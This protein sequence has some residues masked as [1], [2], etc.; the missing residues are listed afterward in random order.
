MTTLLDC[1]IAKETPDIIKIR[2]NNY[3]H[4]KVH[5][6]CL[7]YPEAVSIFLELLIFYQNPIKFAHNKLN[8]KP[9]TV[10]HG[11]LNHVIKDQLKGNQRRETRYNNKDGAAEWNHLCRCRVVSSIKKPYQKPINLL[12]EEEKES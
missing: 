5:A 2:T 4:Y 11:I 10:S 9:Q 12:T 1:L 3:I 7:T 6:S 8:C